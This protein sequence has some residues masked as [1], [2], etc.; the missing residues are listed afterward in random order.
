MP[1]ADERIEKL[2]AEVADLRKALYRLADTVLDEQLCWARYP[3]SKGGPQW[4][5]IPKKGRAAR[6]R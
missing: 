4:T 1:D 5:R 3:E 6:A 2:E